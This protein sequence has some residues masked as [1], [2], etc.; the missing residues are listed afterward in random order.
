MSEL[1]RAA[2]RAMKAKARRLAGADPHQKVDASSWTE[3]EPLNTETKTGMRPI[4]QRQYKRGGKVEGEGARHHAGHKQRKSGGRLAA[5]LMNRDEKEANRERPGGKDHI[6]GYKKGGR[7]HRMVGGM[8][9]GGIGGMA[10]PVLL[11]GAGQAAAAPPM[12]SPD[13]AR[14]PAAPAMPPISSPLPPMPPGVVMPP[15]SANG[16]LSTPLSGGIGGQGRFGFSFPQSGRG[17]FPG[18][19]WKRGGKTKHADEREDEALI[20]REV[21]PEAL[22]RRHGGRARA[23]WA[24][25]YMRGGEASEGG[26]EH[27]IAGAIKHPGALHRE[28]GVPQGEKIP[29]KK[30]AKAKHSDNPLLRKRANLASTLGKMHKAAG[31]SVSDGELEGTRPL[32]GGRMAHAKGGKAGRGKMNVNII[33]GAGHGAQDAQTTPGG[34][35]PPGGPPRPPGAVPVAMPPTTPPMGGGMMPMPIPMPMGGASAPSPL[36]GTVPRKRGGRTVAHEMAEH[37]AG[38]GSGLGRLEK[39]KAYGRR[40]GK[41][42][43]SHY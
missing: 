3:A 27:W 26:G 38:G 37:G 15:I 10:P 7:L 20:R 35:L 29:A 36:G 11:G 31:G 5:T 40:E 1:S 33:I 32:R 4:S 8:Q 22:K 23:A 14:A 39:I 16:P 43:S 17:M 12:E 41:R 9:P 34:M 42:D 30:L 2:R 18:T 19:G 28:L 13:S 21:K 25:E 6:G 24:D